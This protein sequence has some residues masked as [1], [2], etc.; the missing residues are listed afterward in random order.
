MLNSVPEC[1]QLPLPARAEPCAPVALVEVD[2]EEERGA[3]QRPLDEVLEAEV[4]Q[5]DLKWVS[6]YEQIVQHAQDTI[7]TWHNVSEMGGDLILAQ[8]SMPQ[9][10]MKIELEVHGMQ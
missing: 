7:S 8:N 2:H 1:A 5:A 4:G 10:L 6:W 3:V 9:N